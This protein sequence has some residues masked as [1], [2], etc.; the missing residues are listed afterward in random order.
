MGNAMRRSRGGALLSV[1][2]RCF[3]LVLKLPEP[4]AAVV[5]LEGPLA[6]L[7]LVLM[8]HLSSLNLPSG[9]L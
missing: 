5:S 9:S 4:P 1:K 3:A 7:S 2:W 8:P 6:C